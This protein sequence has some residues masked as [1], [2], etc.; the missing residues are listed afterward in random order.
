MSRILCKRCAKTF[1]KESGLRW[2]LL[3]IHECRDVEELLMEPSP[4]MLAKVAAWRE[5]GLAAFAKG[6]GI[7]IQTARDLIARQFPEYTS[8]PPSQGTTP[9]MS[10]A[11]VQEVKMS[12]AP[13]YMPPMLPGS[14]LDIR[15]VTPKGLPA[16]GFVEGP[17]M[18]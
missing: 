7:D 6:L 8:V 5:V 4:G 15:T 18:E 11:N 13:P 16:P 14:S 1:K 17:G 12:N 10:T 3:H 2:H 9:D